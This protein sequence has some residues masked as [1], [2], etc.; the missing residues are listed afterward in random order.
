LYSAF[1]LSRGIG[2][3][4]NNYRASNSPTAQEDLNILIA[5]SCHYSNAIT[6][7]QPHSKHGFGK[8]HAPICQLAV[9]ES[10]RLPGEDHSCSILIFGSL[11]FDQIA[12]SFKQ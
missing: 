7:P 11:L 10:N 6:I 3:V 2:I 1:Q 5:V 4:Q 8:Y 12:Q 9:R